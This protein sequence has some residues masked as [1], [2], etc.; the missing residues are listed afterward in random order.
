[1]D[2]ILCKTIEPIISVL[3]PSLP[4]L[5]FQTIPLKRPKN[6]LFQGWII[7]WQFPQHK[8]SFGDSSPLESIH[9]LAAWRLQLPAPR[10][11]IHTVIATSRHRQISRL[12]TAGRQAAGAF[13]LKTA[14]FIF[15]D[16]KRVRQNRQQTTSPKISTTIPSFTPT[17][18]TVWSPEG[19]FWFLKVVFIL[20]NL[21]NI[22]H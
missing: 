12:H 20:C 13:R 15:W 9:N 6:A 10:R 11:T 2:C 3:V 17:T 19:E 21:I 7:I 16:H 8:Y 14:F 4:I 22:P 18:I 5:H 1:M